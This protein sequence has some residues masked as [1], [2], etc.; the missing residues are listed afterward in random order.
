M[1]TN[2]VFNLGGFGNNNT[3]TSFGSK[4]FGSGTTGGGLFG[5]G[6]TSTPSFGGGF[7]S[8]NNTSSGFGGGNT[9]GGLF[10]QNKT[11][12]GSSTTGTT[13]GNTL[14]GGGNT[15]GFGAST[16]GGFGSS[17][18]SGFGAGGNQ[19]QQQQQQQPNNGTASTPFNAYSEKDAGGTQQFQ[20][21]TFQQ[22]YTNYSLEELRVVD[23]NQGRRYGNQNG[24]AGAFGQSTGFGGF[25]NTSNT[26]TG[27][28]GSGTNT[29]S[30]LFGNNNTTS[31][32]GQNN[33]TT[34]FG[35]NTNTSG[36]GLFGQNKPATGLFGSTTASQP[37]TG[38]G[39]FGSSN[40]NTGGA[41][42]SAG[43]GF[44]S[45]TSGG[46]GL[47]GQQN[48]TQNKPA[49]GGFGS[50][51]TGT[52]N[53]FGSSTGTG[54]FGSNNNT[55][56]GGLFGQQ[57]QSQTSSAPAFGGANQTSTTGGGLFGSSTGGG[58]LFGNNQQNQQQNQ[59]PGGGLFS[60]FGSNNQQNQQKPAGGLFGSS[61]TNTS[62]GGGLFGQNNQTQQSGG[63]FGQNQQNQNQ[64]A[65]LF[66]NANKPAT[67]GGL[68]GSSTQNTGNTGGGLF[69]GLNNSNQQ[70]QGSSLFGGQ[71]QQKPGGL[72][73]SST[74]N[75]NTGGGLFGG[76]LGQSNN[77]G[78]LGGSLFSSQNQ[79]QQPQQ[80]TNSLFGASGGSSLL[81]TS[82][83]TNP[84][85]NDALFSNLATPTQSP[86]PLA[87]PLSSS[88]KTRKSAI[89]PQ[90]KL[91]PSASTRLLTPQNKRIGGYGFTYSTYGTPNSAS[92][93]SSPGFS[94][95]LFGSGSL[96]RSL[97][98]SLSTSNLRNSYTPETSILAPGAF[99][100][101]GRS[102][103]TGS[104]KKLNINR[105]INNRVPLFDEPSPDKK[106]V[107]FVGTSN[108][109]ENATTNGTNGGELQGGE[110]VLRADPAEGTAVEKPSS[111]ASSTVNGDSANGT[112]SRPEMSQVNGNELTPVPEN[113]A[114]SSRSASSLNKQSST[115]DPTP[116][117]YYSRPSMDQL[118]KMSRAELTKVKD[119]VVGRERIGEIHFNPGNPV[120]VSGVD[121]DKLFGDIVQLNTRNAT[122]Y[123]ES[124]TVPKPARG[125][126]LNV[127]SRIS[128]F[129]SW[130][131]NR[132]GKKDTKHVERLKRVH[133]TTF[134][135][136]RHATGE[137]I[138]TVPHFSS[139]GLDYN[140]ENYSD[141]DMEDE[142][143]EGSSD[144]D[145]APDTPAQLRSSQMTGTPHEES[146][147]SHTQSSPDDTFDFKK[148]KLKRAS[149]PG[150]YG[151]Q[152][153]YEEEEVEDAM[154]MTGGESF[155][156]ERSVGS[157]DGQLDADYTE[158]SES[159]PGEDQDMAGS[160]SGPV[161]TTEQH[162]NESDPFKGSAL[163]PK[164]ILKNSQV[165]RP[166]FGTPS[167]GPLVFD[168]DWANQ[169][170]RTIS[171][172][173]Q[174]RHA[175]R[176]SQ[177]NVLR[178][179]PEPVQAMAHSTNEQTIFSRMDMMESLFG[180]TDKDKGSMTK[181]TGPGIEV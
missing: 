148:G 44:G 64:G 89:L 97:G 24:Q 98:K 9:G 129:N 19:Q 1:Y 11:G 118:R 139:Y 81:Q 75:T 59:Q 112:S 63:L 62:G 154:E 110:L 27:G 108:G 45:S 21:I 86:G 20:T 36:G 48:Q 8:N 167:K 146:P 73:G 179:R 79:Q 40:T 128:L 41:F 70:N 95:S 18:T 22:P 134:V 137:W 55:T 25:G 72:F 7:G 159:E 101:N 17:N 58:G 82:M 145:P 127:P 133:G 100:T 158:E 92:T 2:V 46:G 66:G 90:H 149:V 164:S 176:E 49:F 131:R 178:E 151:D 116:G 155:L 135:D 121:L 56:G 50:G 37:S 120:D 114:L 94:S 181:R 161:R 180:T 52:N 29:G 143:D 32:F 174:D 43:T 39:L 15:G 84:Y 103:A 142:V 4:P 99:S 160:V 71:N 34:A 141:D 69:G 115:A 130:P 117:Q 173:K 177:G 67:T 113:G 171:P 61:A 76:G 68:F 6:S 165:L 51:A 93:N 74:T 106:R 91:N 47:F 102:F 153:A 54:A 65:G 163:P 104:L 170:Q 109:V 38:G 33:T 23:Y 123:G 96:S 16:G 175:L 132:N 30:G 12:F 124:T 26:T 5:G 138:F 78:V 60:G 14:F 31:S 136:Y 126:G 105:S 42:G 156:G 125:T 166:G 152:V 77:T 147:V 10:G 87:T 172:K 53:A 169:L 122:V 85:G 119:F 88:Q 57:Q 80:S 157:L 3:T 13:G 150:G 28:F 35:S 83:N 144:L 140:G 111:G 162:V 168:D 107:S